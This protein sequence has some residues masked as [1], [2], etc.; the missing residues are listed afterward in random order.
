MNQRSLF[1][2]YRFLIFDGN[3]TLRIVFRNAIFFGLL[4][5]STTEKSVEYQYTLYG[6]FLMWAKDFFD[7]PNAF[8]MRMQNPKNPS[9]CEIPK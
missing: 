7:M 6:E 9:L 4:S 1:S 3:E 2:T 8:Q 5:P